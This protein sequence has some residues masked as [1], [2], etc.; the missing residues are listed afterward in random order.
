M[1]NVHANKAWQEWPSKVLKLIFF[2]C[3][4]S[5]DNLQIE[6]ITWVLLQKKLVKDKGWKLLTQADMVNS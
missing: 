5:V 4:S 1:E 2:P 3:D 6:L